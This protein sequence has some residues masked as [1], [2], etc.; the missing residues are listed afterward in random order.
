MACL[1]EVLLRIFMAMSQVKGIPSLF[2]VWEP[3]RILAGGLDKSVDVGLDGV[4]DEICISIQAQR[5]ASR[6]SR[7]IIMD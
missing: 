4:L 3:L 1:N 2:D 7:I 6:E 5:M